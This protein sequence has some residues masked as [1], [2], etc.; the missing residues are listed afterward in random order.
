VGVAYVQNDEPNE[1]DAKQI[2]P[3]AWIS[4]TVIGFSD[5]ACFLAIPG[6]APIHSCI[7]QG[8]VRILVISCGYRYMMV[9]HSIIFMML[10]LVFTF[11]ALGNELTRLTEVGFTFHDPKRD[12]DKALLSVEDEHEYLNEMD[13]LHKSDFVNQ[14]LTRGNLSDPVTTFLWYAIVLLFLGF[15]LDLS[16]HVLEIIGL[17]EATIT[18]P[19]GNYHF[20]F[21][22]S[23]FL[24]PYINLSA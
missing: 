3:T 6:S 5:L 13:P 9:A 2:A 24:S 17:H 23:L 14:S 18:A 16:L 4:V 8:F 22:L 10:V 20:F 7:L 15:S 21:P 1:I 11:R 12:I 19:N